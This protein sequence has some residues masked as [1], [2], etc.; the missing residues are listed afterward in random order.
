MNTDQNTQDK[1][2]VVN[3]V[4]AGNFRTLSNALRAADLVTTFKG[5]GPFTFFAPTDDAFEKLPKGTLDALLKDKAKLGA[6]L[7]AHVMKGAVHA[8]DLKARQSQSL[9]G[10]PLAIATND[11]GIT[12]NGA[13]V[14]KNEIEASNGVIH[15]IDT[16]LMP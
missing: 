2:I 7:N 5:I 12:V 6:L 9:Q 15:G 8:R 10:L 16:V 14:S 3:A 13:K 11:A 4:N 1:D